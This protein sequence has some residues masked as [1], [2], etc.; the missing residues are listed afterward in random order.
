MKRAFWAT[1]AQNAVTYHYPAW[2]ANWYV[3]LVLRVSEEYGTLQ[4]K[5]GQWQQSL[6]FQISLLNGKMNPVVPTAQKR[7][8]SIYSGWMICS[9]VVSNQRCNVSKRFP[10]GYKDE[11]QKG[12]VL[13]FA[14]RCFVF[15]GRQS[16]THCRE[17]W[18]TT[19]ETQ[20]KDRSVVC[21]QTLLNDSTDDRT[22]C[23]SKA[24]RSR[25]ALASFLC[26][27]FKCWSNF[28]KLEPFCNLRTPHIHT[29]LFVVP[30]RL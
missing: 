9:A 12:K 22:A 24:L 6:V 30:A 13:V 19:I 15:F 20:S 27:C 5:C 23:C 21:T 2:H 7:L 28:E 10:K 18:W 3:A 26:I 16:Q 11:L 17:L 25:T 29:Q 4:L 14:L 1:H 8:V